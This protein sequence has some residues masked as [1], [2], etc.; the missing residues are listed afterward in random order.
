MTSCV[1]KAAN[2]GATL[3]IN[4]AADDYLLLHY[5]LFPEEAALGVYSVNS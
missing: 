2:H 4:S 3:V 1:Q 5:F